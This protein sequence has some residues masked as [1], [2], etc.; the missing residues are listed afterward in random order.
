MRS[1]TQFVGN[2][3]KRLI[4][5]RVFQEN[6]AYQFFPKINVSPPDTQRYVC[7][8]GVKKRLFFGKFGVLCFL[9]TPISRLTLLTFDLLPTIMPLVFSGCVDR[10]QW[11]K[12]V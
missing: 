4:S 6:K 1:L 9:E 2:K 11:L 7:V 12:L 8:S 5:K 10:V 3:A